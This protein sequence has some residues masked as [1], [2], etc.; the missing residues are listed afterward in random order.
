M[1][2]YVID[3]KIRNRLDNVKNHGWQTLDL[4]NCN[5]E[6]IPSEIFEY[7]HLKGDGC[8]RKPSSE[9]VEII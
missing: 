5:L 4:R 9:A 3:E 6:F 2:N 7:A 1:E 8:F